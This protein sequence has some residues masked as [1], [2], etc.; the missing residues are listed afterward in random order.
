VN[1]TFT[2]FSGHFAYTMVVIMRHGFRS[3]NAKV[4][5]DLVRI[6]EAPNRAPVAQAAPR[7]SIAA[8]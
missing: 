8:I 1:V 5:V 4:I 7:R 6:M 2:H 3:K